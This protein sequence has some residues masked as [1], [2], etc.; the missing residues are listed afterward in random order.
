M[1]NKG[2]VYDIKEAGG[3]G[4]GNPYERSVD[5]VLDDVLDEL[6]SLKSA[7]EE[8]GVVIDPETMRVDVAATNKLRGSE[9]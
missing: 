8:Y 7:R 3:G 6:V 4:Y 5:K 2:D 1:L 9:M